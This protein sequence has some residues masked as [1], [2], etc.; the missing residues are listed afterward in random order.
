MQPIGSSI[1]ISIFDDRIEISN[2][3]CLPFGMTL[4]RAL[5]G[6]S[7]VRNRVIA[8][9]FKEL[10]LIEQWGS[11]LQRV[12]AACK[13]HGLPEPLFQEFENEFKVTLFLTKKSRKKTEP[14]DKKLSNYIKKN[15]AISTKEA[16]KLWN[17]NPRN[18][19][20]RL[21]N[22]VKMGHLKKTGSNPYDPHSAYTLA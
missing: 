8:R 17:I 4:E 7:K 20:E 9:V 3:G 18:A 5:T 2:P 16:A 11:G 15:K 22:F 1:I 6:F 10:K 19:R 14:F 21:K 13:K 12:I